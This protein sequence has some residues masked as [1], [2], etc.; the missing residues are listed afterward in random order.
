MHI[1]WAGLSKRLRHKL[2]LGGVFDPPQHPPNSSL[3]KRGSSHI[4][5]GARAAASPTHQSEAG[6]SGST[7]GAAATSNSRFHHFAKDLNKGVWERGLDAIDRPYV[8]ARHVT[9]PDL[10]I[11]N[12]DSLHL[13]RG[14]RA[15]VVGG[16][17]PGGP[18][19]TG[20]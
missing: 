6:G 10:Y 11:Q 4:N 5:L 19:T 9:R 16:A 12:N 7:E 8:R 13:L 18:F 2:K 1:V 3:A 20:T 14:R 15:G 17:G